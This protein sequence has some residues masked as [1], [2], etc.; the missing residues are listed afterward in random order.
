MAAP[1]RIIVHC[2]PLDAGLP[3]ALARLSGEG[4]AVASGV[5]LVLGLTG[6]TPEAVLADCLEAG[7]PVRASQVD[8]SC[9]G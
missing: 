2:G 5:V 9:R 7:I 4:R 3:A 6:R 1:T 8:P